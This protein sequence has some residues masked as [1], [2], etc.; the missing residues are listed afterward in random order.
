LAG[1]V[2]SSCFLCG[3][4]VLCGSFFWTSSDNLIRR[5]ILGL[6]S[7]L[8]QTI[9]EQTLV[10]PRPLNRKSNRAAA[11][12]ASSAKAEATIAAVPAGE[13]RSRRWLLAG[14]VALFSARLFIA[15]DL[16]AAQG[17][18]LLLDMLWILLFVLWCIAAIRAGLLKVRFTAIDAAVCG[19]F[20]LVAVGALYHLRESSP[21]LAVNVC[22]EWVTLALAYFL[23]RQC[24][25]SAADARAILGAMVALGVALAALGYFQY[26]VDRWETINRYQTIKY[27][28]V[29]M[30]QVTGHWSP[31]DS[32][33][34]KRFED[35]L[36]SSEPFAR[37]ALAN[38]LA[39][40]LAPWLV[41]AV[42]IGLSRRPDKGFPLG[43]WLTL[44]LA[45]FMA[46]CL[47][48]TKSRS[49]AIAV[50]L[51]LGL[52]W[53]FS[54]R[55]KWPRWLWPAVVG[56]LAVAMLFVAWFAGALDREVFTQAGRSLAFRAQYWQATTQLV[57][58]HPL[59]GV[60]LGQFG[61]NYTQYKLPEASEEIADPHNFLLE[62]AALAGIPALLALIGVLGYSALL[63]YR[64]SSRATLI[65]VSPEEALHGA[66]RYAAGGAIA[67]LFVG[68]IVSL[69]A[70]VPLPLR[71]FC[72]LLVTLLAGLVVVLPWIRSGRLTP[73]VVL[74]GICALLVNLLAA[75]SLVYPAIAGTLWLLVAV[76]ASLTE[77]KRSQKTYIPHVAYVVGALGMLVGLMCY[78]TAYYPVLTSQQSLS[79]SMAAQQRGDIAAAEAHLVA[80]VAADPH[81]AQL[82]MRL[83]EMRYR[84]LPEK[85]TAPEIEKV[86]AAAELSRTRSPLDAALLGDQGRLYLGLFE[87]TGQPEL[88]G[89][90]EGLFRNALECYPTSIMLHA[91]LALT[92]A[93]RNLPDEAT[94]EA[95]LALRLEGTA[96]QAG[97]EDKRIP[98]ELRQQLLR[99]IESSN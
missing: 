56:T 6:N 31:P 39:G 14:C 4:C 79:D 34:R 33:E 92:L 44:A 70:S 43:A 57:S 76:G 75:G 71:S 9:R 55:G 88:L 21:R 37:F 81:S 32:L 83:A 10:T 22:W 86:E 15:G 93:V 41:V 94:S 8:L 18:G 77:G 35:R 87:R 66:Y 69:A 19:F 2:S 17:E 97:H 78:L 90:A 30:L 46:G 1:A 95:R 99:I 64:R 82:A 13:E 49:G 61:L 48:L 62:T 96:L 80:A 25:A 26:T 54:P 98:A 45:I 36:R 60:G 29:Q 28:P 38:S 52:L 20:A 23:I 59:A 5:T 11:A 50:V 89:R 84:L 67:G 27:D 24:I 63:L 47:I 72:I 3:L 7:V 74:V 65:D 16:G 53:A 68:L 91:S 51:G 42:G 40:Y 85:P 12:G 58:D 73:S